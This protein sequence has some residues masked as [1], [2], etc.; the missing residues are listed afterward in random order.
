MHKN[1]SYDAATIEE[2]TNICMERHHPRTLKEHKLFK[3]T[4]VHVSR[5]IIIN[6]KI[7]N[8]KVIGS[9][10]SATI[11]ANLLNFELKTNKVVFCG[12]QSVSS[13]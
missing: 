10:T 7:F 6:R 3:K 9:L 2:E 11:Q 1:D 13:F 5:H 4:W 8:G 12:V